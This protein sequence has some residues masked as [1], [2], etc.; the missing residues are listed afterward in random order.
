MASPSD[1][2]KLLLACS[3][4][5]HQVSFV[6]LESRSWKSVRTYPAAHREAEE[7]QRPPCQSRGM[8]R[9]PKYTLSF[10][11]PL[12]IAIGF[13]RRCIIFI[14]LLVHVSLSSVWYRRNSPRPHLYIPFQQL[15][16]AAIVTCAASVRVL[17]MT[18]NRKC[19]TIITSMRRPTPCMKLHP[20]HIFLS[21]QSSRF[22][23]TTCWR[24]AHSYKLI[25]CVERRLYTVMVLL[26]VV[27]WQDQRK[28]SVH[29]ST[30]SGKSNCNNPSR[31]TAC[32]LTTPVSVEVWEEATGSPRP[33]QQS[34]TRP[35]RR[36]RPT[37]DCHWRRPW[38]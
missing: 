3:S 6:S 12:L 30:V 23:Q 15:A 28:H 1:F 35:V 18:E 17:Y 5:L 33:S 21:E 7:S 22:A 38:H 13:S 16:V 4:W 37:W 9:Q 10:R 27:A 34:R 19:R 8:V 14:T 29:C 20:D 36:R 26:H 24:E 32:G 25:M 11:T 31:L 2:P